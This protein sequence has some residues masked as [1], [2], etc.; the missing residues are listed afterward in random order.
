VS[1]SNLRA[2]AEYV[3]HQAEHHRKRDFRAEYLALLKKHGVEYDPRWV[4]E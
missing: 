3:K 1:A 2:T 4:T